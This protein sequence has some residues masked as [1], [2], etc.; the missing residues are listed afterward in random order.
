MGHYEV[1]V[2][3]GAAVVRMVFIGLPEPRRSGFRRI[4]LNRRTEEG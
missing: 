3:G 4:R 2:L 1:S